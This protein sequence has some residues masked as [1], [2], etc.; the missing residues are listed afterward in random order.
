MY[1]LD[2]KSTCMQALIPTRVRTD[3]RQG[4]L[5]SLPGW[6]SG[7]SASNEPPRALVLLKNSQSGEESQSPKSPRSA[8]A[9]SQSDSQ[10]NIAASKGSRGGGGPLEGVRALRAGS[11]APQLASVGA[12]LAR[13]RTTGCVEVTR[14]LANTVWV[15]A[16]DQELGLLQHGSK[17]YM[18][19]MLIAARGTRCW[20][21]S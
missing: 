9:S 18:V 14:T 19:N 12:L 17:L 6:T 7:P 1:L 21:D 20:I 10:L 3:V 16:V 8:S 15:G 4:K 2:C 5:T 13:C 11:D